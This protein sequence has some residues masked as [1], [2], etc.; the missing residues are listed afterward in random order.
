MFNYKLENSESSQIYDYIVFNDDLPCFII[1]YDQ[2]KKNA[3]Y[4]DWGRNLIFIEN[5]DAFSIRQLIKIFNGE[6]DEFI[7]EVEKES[8][9][10]RTNEDFIHYFLYKKI[11]NQPFEKKCSLLELSSE[12]TEL[13]HK[14]FSEISMLSEV[15][16]KLDPTGPYKILSN[17]DEMEKEIILDIAR[18]LGKE[19]FKIPNSDIVFVGTGTKPFVHFKFPG[20]NHLNALIGLE[21]YNKDFNLS[22]DLSVKQIETEIDP[23]ELEE[24]E[25]P[26]S[27]IVVD[28]KYS[29]TLA[30]G[31][32]T[33]KIQQDLKN[34]YE[35]RSFVIMDIIEELSNEIKLIVM[36]NS[37]DSCIKFL[38][39]E[40]IPYTNI[41][42]VKDVVN[43]SEIKDFI[44]YPFK[45][46]DFT[47]FYDFI[48]RLERTPKI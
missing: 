1:S 25:S 23:E 31:I 40:K 44:S 12:I 48:K 35:L 38:K 11:F 26:S 36:A 46:V 32:S 33:I 20:I 15:T 27:E 47:K 42:E 8:K 41:Y 28:E 21:V 6:N 45:L 13:A 4:Y 7:K 2:G 39:E 34:N 43:T 17:L 14:Y 5:N 3:R 37:K 18:T 22:F 30:Q 29:A 9:I 16:F 19:D 24:K 10:L